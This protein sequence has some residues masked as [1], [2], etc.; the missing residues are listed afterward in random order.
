MGNHNKFLTIKGWIF[1]SPVLHYSSQDT[2]YFGYGDSSGRLNGVGYLH[3]ETNC[4]SFV[5]WD[6]LFLA[7]NFDGA[8]DTQSTAGCE[9]T[10]AKDMKW[11]V[12]TE[13]LSSSLSV[14][15]NDSSL[16]LPGQCSEG[17]NRPAEK[18]KCEN[19]HKSKEIEGHKEFRVTTE[20]S[21]SADFE[22][23]WWEISQKS[24][25]V[26]DMI[27]RKDQWGCVMQGM[28]YRQ[29]IAVKSLHQDVVARLASGEV[30]RE[31]KQ[32]AQI[33][34]PNL[35]LVIGAVLDPVAGPLI[36]TEFLDQTLQSA[37]EDQLLEDHSKLPIL[38]DVA[39]ALNYLHS[40][41]PPIVH[42]NV[43]SGTVLLEALRN[44]RWKAKLSDFGMTNLI[45]LI[46]K[47]SKHNS[48]DGQ[49]DEYSAPE[50]NSD[51]ECHN[52][53]PVTQKIDV[54][55]FGVLLRRISLN[56]LPSSSSPRDGVDPRWIYQLGENCTRLAPHERPTMDDILMQIDGMF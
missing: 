42:G 45:F 2:R 30:Q 21:I 9:Y 46:H 52:H 33:H 14:D 50:L 41:N 36:V 44:G 15:D 38:R 23:E 12:S 56:N 54:Y 47:T 43:N 35:L 20:I 8:S 37:Y 13:T 16:L 10:T 11:A 27:V 28:M 34:H 18:S 5:S 26:S 19:Q 32:V 3:C 39:S 51:V 31:M 7:S 1:K 29:R 55:S 24:V 6:K 49:S 22:R 53:P 48:T 40:Q 25:Q 4:G 17:C